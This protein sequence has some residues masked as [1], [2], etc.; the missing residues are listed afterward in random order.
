MNRLP[1]FSS[2]IGAKNDDSCRI[3]CSEIGAKNDDSCRI[4]NRIPNP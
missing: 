4:P 3:P 2:E 1:L